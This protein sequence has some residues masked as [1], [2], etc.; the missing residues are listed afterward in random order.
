MKIEWIILISVWLVTSGLIFIIPK[1]KRRIAIVAFF[2]N[3][4]ITWIAGLLVVEYHLLSYPVRLFS[5]INR[6][7]FTFEYFV[8]P[9]ICGIFNAFY[10][11]SYNALYKFMYYFI[12]CTILTIPEIFLEKKTDLIQYIHWT[13]Y[14]TWSTLCITFFMTRAF[15]VWFFNGLSKELE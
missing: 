7:S 3:Q 9:V 8:Y 13:W 14:W 12:F 6:S 15:C 11:N 10:P 1:N 4:I 2:F 5:D